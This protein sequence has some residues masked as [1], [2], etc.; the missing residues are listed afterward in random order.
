MLINMVNIVEKNT[1]TDI[2]EN[3]PDV[4]KTAI[5]SI[6]RKYRTS[7]STFTSCSKDIGNLKEP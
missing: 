7:F 1:Q 6:I 4:M 2:N 5:P 3:D